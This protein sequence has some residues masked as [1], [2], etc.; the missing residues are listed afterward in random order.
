MVCNSC[1][2]NILNESANFCEYCGASFREGN[3]HESEHTYNYSYQNGPGNASA[4]VPPP[5]PMHIAG[6]NKNENPVTFKNWLGTFMIRFIP[7]VGSL[8]LFVMLIIWSTGNNVSES[9]KNWAKAQLV[10]KLITFVIFILFLFYI[11][12]VLTSDPEFMDIWNKEMQQYND[13]MNNY[14]Y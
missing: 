8:V 14:S 13:I 6:I 2:R 7:F 4:Q 11:I 9:K 5:L 1:G 3:V 10:Y 12:S